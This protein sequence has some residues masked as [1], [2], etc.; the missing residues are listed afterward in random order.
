[1]SHE[2]ALEFWRVAEARHSLSGKVS[3]AKSL[4]VRPFDLSGVHREN[5]LGLTLPFHILVGSGNV[6]RTS[7][8]LR[9]HVCSREYPGGSF[10]EYPSGLVVSS[11]ELCFLQI[12][13]LLSLEELIM[14]GFELCGSYRIGNR[15]EPSKGFREDSPLTSVAKLKG[16]LIRAPRIKGKVLACQALQFIANHSASPRE[17]VLAM[18]LTLPYRLGG[19]G[20]P[21]PVLNLTIDVPISGKKTSPVKERRC[22]L[23]WQKEQVAVE[24]DSN[25]FHANEDRIAEDAIRRNALIAAGITVI[26]ASNKHIKDAR[27]LRVLAGLLEK[28]LKKRLSIRDKK[29]IARQRTLRASILLK[30]PLEE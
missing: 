11:P 20:F 16:Y 25:A 21:M 7:E 12:A 2:S 26:V 6:R 4:P 29:F 27:E 10:M 1:M 5:P 8:S 13:S 3:R 15:K 18:L 23:F 24:Y 28:L 22:D 14:L 30:A 19:Y 9:F 17:T